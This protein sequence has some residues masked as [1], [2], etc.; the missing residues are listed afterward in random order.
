M[1]QVL[2]VVD[3]QSTFSPPEWLVKGI[4]KLADVVPAVATV[5]LH[6]EQ[7]TRATGYQPLD[8]PFSAHHHLS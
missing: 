7:R 5:E 2:L 6:D 3:V 1:R 4:Q 8:P